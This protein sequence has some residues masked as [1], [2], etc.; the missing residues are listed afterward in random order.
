MAKKYKN[1]KG[2]ISGIFK[3]FYPSSFRYT[4]YD[5]IETVE[6]HKKYEAQRNTNKQWMK[7]LPE[8]K[9]PYDSANQ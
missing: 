4:L 6:Y 7:I 2:N 8:E 3:I 9:T 1:Q 5:T